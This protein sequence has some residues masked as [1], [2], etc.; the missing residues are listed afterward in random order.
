MST[1]MYDIIGIGAIYRDTI[2]TIPHFPAE[3]S[4]LQASTLVSRIGGNVFNSLSVLAQARHRETEV[5]GLWLV[6][7]FCAESDAG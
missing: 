3:D 4:K 6:G 5:V 2:L 1:N 7:A